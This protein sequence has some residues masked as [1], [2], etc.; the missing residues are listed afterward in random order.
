MPTWTSNPLTSGRLSELQEAAPKGDAYAPG[1]S[2]IVRAQ[3]FAGVADT[4]SLVEFDSGSLLTDAP[5]S[6]IVREQRLG[7]LPTILKFPDGWSFHCRDHEEV[8]AI[9]GLRRSDRLHYWEAFRPRLVLVVAFTLMAAF[10]AWRWGLGILVATAI[11]LTPEGMP[12]AIDDGHLAFSDQTWASPSRLGTTE[13][14]RIA[15]VFDRLKAVAPPP[16][17]SDYRLTFRDI[18][19]A[20]PNAFAL[21]GGTVIITDELV[22]AFPDPDVIAG[23]LGHELAHVSET[24]GLKQVY[25]SL[26]TYLA[27]AIVFGDVG[28]VLNDLLLEGGLLF[29][30]AYS[31]EHESEADRIGLTLAAQAGYDPAALAQFFRQLDDDSG[32]SGPGWLSTHPSHQDRIAEIERLAGEIK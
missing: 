22:R 21:P 19:A 9:L 11:F 1:S 14:E 4:I 29:S 8:D 15:L 18:P 23:V 3:L 17:F 20:G 7:S 25:R 26:G 12:R 2:R 13:R 16:R 5:T 6:R 30:L 27:V 10:S 31:R 28:P 32:F 24:H